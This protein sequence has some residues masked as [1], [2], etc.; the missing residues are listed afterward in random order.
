M[1]IEGQSDPLVASR[2]EDSIVRDLV[3]EPRE[4]TQARQQQEILQDLLQNLTSV[5]ATPFAGSRETRAGW[6]WRSWSAGFAR[7]WRT[8]GE[9]WGSNN[10]RLQRRRAIEIGHPALYLLR[11]DWQGVHA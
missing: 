3:Q 6:I 8:D 10:R 9:P 4:V 5:N 1:Q 11:N 7:S 2:A